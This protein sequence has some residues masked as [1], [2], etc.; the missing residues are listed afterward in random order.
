M[1][2]PFV[3]AA[4][5]TFFTT[6]QSGCTISPIIRESLKAGESFDF[7]FHLFNTSNGVPL[8]SSFSCIFHFYNQSGD[9]V[10]S[11]VL[12][13]D[14]LS[15]HGVTNEWGERMNGGN[16]STIGSYAYIVQCNSTVSGCADK[17]YFV[18]T[19]SG[20]DATTG[21]ALIDASL[22]LVLVIFFV[23]ALWIFMTTENLLAKVG[24]IGFGYLMLLA[25]SF[26]SWNMANDFL[27]SAPFL[28]K[29]FRILFI[30]LTIG[31]FPLVLG[32]FAWYFYML[33]KV[34]E[35]ER[36]MTKGFSFDEAKRR[37]HG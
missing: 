3:N 19:N 17:G 22:L 35:I 13:N 5:P 37:T 10:F 27:L 7:N 28:A 20:Y 30:S 2:L 36:L 34:K 12:T 33:F 23:F 25:I 8:S 31:F 9:H 32:G 1:I 18:V 26:V 21:R 16:I 14:P 29:I 6:T 15:E 11:K 24:M 4:Q